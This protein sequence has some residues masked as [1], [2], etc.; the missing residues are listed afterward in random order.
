MSCS[1][2]DSEFTI[3]NKPWSCCT[4]YV[5]QSCT[6]LTQMHRVTQQCIFCNETNCRISLDQNLSE[7]VYRSCISHKVKLDFFCD[8]HYVAFCKNCSSFHKNCKFK[9]LDIGT[10]QI[11]MTN[12][13]NITKG[14][15][16]EY[17]RNFD[18]I[19][20]KHLKEYTEKIQELKNFVKDFINEGKKFRLKLMELFEEA[21]KT[22]EPTEHFY[23]YSDGFS[24]IR[25][26]ELFCDSK[27]EAF[28]DSIYKFRQD[29]T[30]NKI[31]L[32]QDPRL[33]SRSA[34]IFVTNN[35]KDN[36]IFRFVITARAELPVYSVLVGRTLIPNSYGTFKMSIYPE[37][38]SLSKIAYCSETKISYSNSSNLQEIKVNCLRTLKPNEFYCIEYEYAGSE[39]YFTS[40]DTL[41]LPTMQISQVKVGEKKSRLFGI[42]F[43]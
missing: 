10:A 18:E 3:K 19:S 36:R 4:F 24:K 23:L 6:E 7:L 13:R 31:E 26:F 21:K 12:A 28:F 20:N 42:E 9:K 17:I 35:I 14:D 29:F 33:F 41:A 38:E 1:F 25:E 5:C 2:C 30:I 22:R 43:K 39:T 40:F 15:I 16:E 34:E 32:P 11:I 27:R 8:T 37:E